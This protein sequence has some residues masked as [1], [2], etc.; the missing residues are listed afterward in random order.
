MH[1]G[2]IDLQHIQRK[3]RQLGQARITGAELV[4]RQQHPQAVQLLQ[5][6]AAELRLTHQR[7]L[8][9]FQLQRAGRQAGLRQDGL[10]A[11]DETFVPELQRRH[12][13]CHRPAQQLTVAPQAGLFTGL[14]QHP[15]TDLDNQPAILGN[16]DKAAGLQLPQLRMIPAQQSLGA[17][18][19]AAGQINLGL[20]VQHKLMPF[21]GHAQFGFDGLP[22]H[23][24]ITHVAG[25][26]LVIVAAPLFRLVHG[27]IGMFDQ[28]LGIQAI[29]RVRADAN[30]G[31]NH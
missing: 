10:K 21:Q 28:S 6:L 8:A 12:I 22:G 29:G 24:L 11:G 3:L 26:K 15:A 17:G 1:K 19:G 25:K 5:Y 30:T 23:G 13:H 9:E 20:V 31:G 16:R 18:D 14:V 27:A 7:T 2:L 4:H